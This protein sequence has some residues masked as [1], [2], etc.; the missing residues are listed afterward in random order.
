M[1]QN[2]CTIK[3]YKDVPLHPGY[4]DVY[5]GSYATWL[6]TAT[7]ITLLNQAFQNPWSGINRPS[8]TV[9]VNYDFET[10][11]GY[12][13]LS[14]QNSATGRV[15]FAF[16]TATQ[17]LGAGVTRLTYDIDVWGTWHEA[18]TFGRCYVE[19]EHVAADTVDNWGVCESL[20]YTELVKGRNA[21]ILKSLAALKYYL[22][23]SPPPRKEAIAG[24][25]DF[26]VYK[27][28]IFK[29]SGLTLITTGFNT[30]RTACDVW[31]GDATTVSAALAGENGLDTFG[32][33]DYLVRAFASP[34]D[35][36]QA[37]EDTAE[38]CKAGEA[39]QGYAP[40][41]NKCFDSPF[42]KVVVGAYH[43]GQM[44]FTAREIYRGGGLQVGIRKNSSIG[45]GMSCVVAVPV[46]YFDKAD[47]LY[48]QVEADLPVTNAPGQ[49]REEQLKRD[50]LYSL[51]PGIISG[52]AGTV[53]TGG[54]IAVGAL[55]AGAATAVTGAARIN[56]T[57]SQG[58]STR[59]PSSG[60]ITG[61]LETG[62]FGFYYQ[63]WEMPADAAKRIDEYFDCYGYA[64]QAYKV[65]NMVG[66]SLYNFVK[67]QGAAVSGAIPG[68]ALE[69]LQRVLDSGVRIWH[70]APG[71]AG[72][73]R[74]AENG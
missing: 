7:Q 12:N 15:F 31:K 19:R 72:A 10:L 16:I 36:G 30:V 49:T 73:N 11:E 64:V 37:K 21:P 53:L 29:N 44:T 40:H 26:E 46:G 68:G 71:S 18:A 34:L 14:F 35:Y 52:V 9:T 66:M 50:Y 62:R 39:F 63:I 8:A 55:A 3:L 54:N 1:E 38:V 22:I 58:T 74:R 59:L 48:E 17:A 13:Y 56:D 32:L 69:T 43:G 65:P 6:E 42:R 60:N 25:T 51:I 70:T 28:W 24:K 61:D 41:N 2:S 20:N 5:G 57:L 67:T 33:A 27:D 23:I 47:M 4:T 45:G